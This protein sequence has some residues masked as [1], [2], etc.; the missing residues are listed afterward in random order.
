LKLDAVTLSRLNKI[1]N[2]VTSEIPG[3]L[4]PWDKTLLKKSRPA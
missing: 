3:K 2:N 1:Y 4:E